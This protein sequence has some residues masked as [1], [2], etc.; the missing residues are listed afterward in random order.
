MAFEGLFQLKWVDAFMILEATLFF[1]FRI[2]RVKFSMWSS[3]AGRWAGAAQPMVLDRGV[4]DVMWECAPQ[5]GSQQTE[6]GTLHKAGIGR[7]C[8]RNT[9]WTDSTELQRGLQ[10]STSPVLIWG[11]DWDAQSQILHF[12]PLETPQK[13]QARLCVIMQ[14]DW[15]SLTPEKRDQSSTS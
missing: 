1:A 8:K 3:R 9:L 12:K 5:Q 14:S 2:S 6:Q 15:I 13:A 7:K 4:H 11:W 10:K